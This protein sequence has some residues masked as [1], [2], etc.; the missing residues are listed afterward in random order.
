LIT[1]QRV[2]DARRGRKKRSGGEREKGRKMTKDK[3]HKRQDKS[4]MGCGKKVEMEG[5][6]HL[7]KKLVQVLH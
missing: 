7:F 4:Q 3:S 6:F 5:C 1:G 2:T